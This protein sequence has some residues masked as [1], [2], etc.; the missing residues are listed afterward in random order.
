MNG[1]IRKLKDKNGVEFYPLTHESAIYSG[2][3]VSL[4]QKELLRK[5]AEDLR[6]A[7]EDIRVA[8]F[9][10]ILNSSNDIIGAKYLELEETYATDLTEAKTQL[11]EKATKQDIANMGSA[12]PKGTYATLSALQTA[13]PTGTTGIYIVTAD[14]GWYY[15]NGSAWTKGGTY[16][17]TGIGASSITWDKT[18]FIEPGKNATF[19]HTNI[20]NLNTISIKGD[21]A[22]PENGTITN[23]E[24]TQSY[25]NT[26]Y[27][28]VDANEKY[29]MNS[30]IIQVCFYN[31]SKVFISSNSSPQSG[32]DV[33]INGKTG[34]LLTIP[35]NCVYIMAN[36]TDYEYSLSEI[37]QV[38]ST[39]VNIL[40]M[41]KL[42]LNTTAVKSIN[43]I[44]PDLYGNVNV[45][46]FEGSIKDK[47]IVHFGDSICQ[48]AKYPQIITERT[49]AVTYNCGIGGTS[50]AHYDLDYGYA[51]FFDLTEAIKNNNWTTLDEVSSRLYF[52]DKIDLI[53]T[54]DF[55]KVDIV[56]IAYGTN[57]FGGNLPIGQNT[58]IEINRNFKGC[59]RRGIENLLLI[60]P[61]L[62]IYF[63]TPIYRN[64]VQPSGGNSDENDNGY[65]KYLKDYVQAYFDM[66]SILHFP[67]L[68]LYNSSGIN[69]FNANLLLA[70]N[71]HPT[72]LGYEIIGQKVCNFI[73][74]N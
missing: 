9:D 28:V 51:S 26:G 4:E 39:N 3:G 14:G 23:T 27:L 1:N 5:N 57:D 46:K 44:K 2:D 12:S 45:A 66:Q 71:L 10:T 65:G 8:N 20:I 55:T 64:T 62:K 74:S 48:G 18:N 56:T 7:N 31:P 53:K 32:T 68:N 63:I 19:Q 61:K 42:D 29:I 67:V 21:W 40:T 38:T 50:M 22:N 49:G 72:E 37:W 70:D 34:K 47:T 60:N 59:M 73:L 30:K 17:S 15:W 54:I 43:N 33:T 16:Q 35:T 11:A 58:D 6:I 25:R 41:P 36:I 24:L 69:R 13:Y 52:K